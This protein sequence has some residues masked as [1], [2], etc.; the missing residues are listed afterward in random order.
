MA[1][2]SKDIFAADIH[3]AGIFAAGI[4]RGSYDYVWTGQPN[5]AT[6]AED[7]MTA[8]LAEDQ[9]TATLGARAGD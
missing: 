5:S 3:A 8:T 9:M 2:S 7:Q 4:W 6:L 1:T